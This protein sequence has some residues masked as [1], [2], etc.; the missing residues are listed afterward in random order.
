MH[1]VKQYF[2]HNEK[3][4]GLKVK[5]LNV[6][7]IREFY[8]YLSVHG[9]LVHRKSDTDNGLSRK[10][11]KH[12]STLIKGAF[13]EAVECMA[14]KANPARG[15][16][17]LKRVVKELLPRNMMNFLIQRKRYISLKL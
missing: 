13:D 2:D 1:L 14:L 17:F 10:S 16:K 5:D 3:A 6:Q 9:R 15:V 7:H 11:I 12:V 8:E 4:N